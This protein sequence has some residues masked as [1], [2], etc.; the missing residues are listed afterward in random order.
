LASAT[1]GKP[2]ADAERTILAVSH[3]RSALRRADHIVV[4]KDGRVEAAGT[5]SELLATCTEMQRL[6][7]GEV[8]HSTDSVLPS[9]PRRQ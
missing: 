5:F 3:R 2:G 4:L 6:W 7:A 1:A 8:G 9:P